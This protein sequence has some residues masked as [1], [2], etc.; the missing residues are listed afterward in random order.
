MY[1][2]IAN[3]ILICVIYISALCSNIDALALCGIL[4]NSICFFHHTG[5]L[6][7]KK[8]ESSDCLMMKY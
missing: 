5:G 2:F 8:K 1:F 7:E 3:Y 6:I 4:K